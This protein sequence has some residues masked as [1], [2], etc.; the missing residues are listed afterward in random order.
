MTVQSL[1]GGVLVPRHH[2]F[3]S[4]HYGALMVGGK[5]F[6]WTASSAYSVRAV[7]AGWRGVNALLPQYQAKSVR[8]YKAIQDKYQFNPSN[9]IAADSSGQAF[10]MNAAPIPNLNDAQR[11]AC[12]RPGGLDGSRTD[13]MWNSDPDAV[14]PGIFGPS[15]MPSITRTDH[16]SNM[17][18]SYWLANPAQPLY[19][20]DSSLGSIDVARTPRTR[21]GLAQI[22]ERI[23]GTDGQPG[24]KFTR[25]Q[26]Q[27]MAFS[28]VAYMGRILRDD[29]VTLCQKNPL[30]TVS[31]TEVDIRPACPVLAEWDMKDNL[32][33]RGAHLFRE[34][35]ALSMVRNYR[36]P[37]DLKDPVNTPCGLDTDNNPA[38]LQALAGAVQ[39]LNAASIALGARLG[40]IQHVSRNGQRIA[41]HG[42]T[43]P[44]GNL[45][46]INAPFAGAAAY[47]EVL[48]VTGKRATVARGVLAYSQSANPASPHYSDMTQAYSAKRWIELPFTQAEVA[49]AAVSTLRLVEGPAQCASEGWRRFGNPAFADQ[50]GCE[51]HFKALRKARLSEID[52]RRGK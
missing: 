43:N 38:V 37:F 11:A 46:I 40:D 28:N 14:I 16:A 25:D 22:A 5:P 8:E 30:V 50:A 17:N 15:K 24:R 42:G 48:E 39:K 18:D 12:A 3:Y 36:V 23:A 51:T 20:F 9:L 49:A 2:I 1:E 19:G 27:D 41:V 45:N 21:S 47:P 13:C 10:Y 26:L 44:S 7:D 35:A 52:A 31:G 32:V 6:P 33:S 4:T 34:F 29:L